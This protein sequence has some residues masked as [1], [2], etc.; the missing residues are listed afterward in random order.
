MARTQWV[1][2]S[3]LPRVGGSGGDGGRK[4][5][6]GA[7]GRKKERDRKHPE[8]FSRVWRSTGALGRTRLGLLPRMKKALEAAGECC[9]TLMMGMAPPPPSAAAAEDAAA[10]PE[11][12]IIASEDGATAALLTTALPLSSSGDR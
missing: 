11:A 7:S 9:V 10:A 3:V 2:T 5:W 8:R 12:S 4:R 1:P 6:N